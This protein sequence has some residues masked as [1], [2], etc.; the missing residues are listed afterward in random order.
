MSLRMQE[1]DSLGMAG[2]FEINML[3]LFRVIKNSATCAKRNTFSLKK[4]IY[5]RHDQLRDDNSG[6][7]LD[8]AEGVKSCV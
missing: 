4:K 1:F 3:G 7:L 2:R 6:L 5:P 8:V